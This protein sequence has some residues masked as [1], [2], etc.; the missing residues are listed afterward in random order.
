MEVTSGLVAA[1]GPSPCYSC[2][3]PTLVLFFHPSHCAFREQS[4]LHS[5]EALPRKETSVYQTPDHSLPGTSAQ[6]PNSPCWVEEWTHLRIRDMPRAMH[7]WSSGTRLRVVIAAWLPSFSAP[8]YPAAPSLC[9]G[10]TQ[11]D[12]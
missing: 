11:S 5:L 8:P 2:R 3:W 6:A 9:F 4:P 12:G 1:S 10:L 7:V